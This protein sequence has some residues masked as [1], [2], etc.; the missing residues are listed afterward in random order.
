[1]LSATDARG[2]AFAVFACSLGVC[3][4]PLAR[5]RPSND[6]PAADSPLSLFP[7]SHADEHD[8]HPLPGIARHGL[9]QVRAFYR[10]D[11]GSAAQGA[12]LSLCSPSLSVPPAPQQSG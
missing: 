4:L 10:H 12:F 5:A 8:P 1:M 11:L 9:A 6:E 2:S 7:L 3:T